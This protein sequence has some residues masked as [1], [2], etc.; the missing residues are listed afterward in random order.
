MALTTTRR[1][2]TVAPHPAEIRAEIAMR[3]MTLTRLATEAG[4]DESACRV[5]LIRPL[6]SAEKAISRFLG[7]PLHQLWPDRWD[8]EGRRY[9]NVRDENNHDRDVA[10]SQNDRAA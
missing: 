4:L 1:G 10:H 9:R 5:A 6:L 2:K 7:V 8:A 3:G